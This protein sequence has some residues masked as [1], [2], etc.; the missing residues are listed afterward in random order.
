V[1]TRARNHGAGL[2]FIDLNFDHG[3]RIDRTLKCRVGRLFFSFAL[4]PDRPVRCLGP[5]IVR[6]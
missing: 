2:E 1:P 4:F 3:L 6:M 5:S